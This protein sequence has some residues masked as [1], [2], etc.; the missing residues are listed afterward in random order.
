MTRKKKT[1]FPK[2]KLPPRGTKPKKS[3]AVATPNFTILNPGGGE[4]YKVFARY[5]TKPPLGPC[6]FKIFW[7][8]GPYPANNVTIS[9]I[10]IKNWVVNTVVAA[11]LSNVAPGQ[12]GVAQFTLP[13]N[14]QA[15]DDC[16]TSSLYPLKYGRYQIYIQG[17]SPL[18]WIYGPE[19]TIA[20]SE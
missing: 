1:L 13:A 12:I 18:T 9:L 7:K 10:D 5:P 3:S 11:N 8:D 20:W 2:I 6:T 17:G 14:F 4:I 16:P 15:T 19:F